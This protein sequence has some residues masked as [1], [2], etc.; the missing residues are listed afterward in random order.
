MYSAAS[1]NLWGGGRAIGSLGDYRRLV[2]SRFIN[3]RGRA[4]ER[5]DRRTLGRSPSVSEAVALGPSGHERMASDTC[6][7]VLVCT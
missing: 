7:Y 2:S 4:D 6:S 1:F 5:T 3:V